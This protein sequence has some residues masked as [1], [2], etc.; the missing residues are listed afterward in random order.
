MNRAPHS[1]HL[2]GPSTGSSPG[3]LVSI[4]SPHSVQIN[5]SS[6]KRSL[7]DGFDGEGEQHGHSAL[8]APKPRPVF[9]PVVLVEVS[10]ALG[11]V[12]SDDWLS[13]RIGV[14]DDFLHAQIERFRPG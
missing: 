2:T 12:H 13:V 7:R 10:M 5:R 4:T 9:D 11:T 3:V 6:S 1:G 8:V 14:C